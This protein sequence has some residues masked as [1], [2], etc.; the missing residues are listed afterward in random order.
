MR[1]MFAPRDSRTAWRERRRLGVAPGMELDR[2]I[3]EA[4]TLV[5]HVEVLLEGVV[6]RR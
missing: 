2:W 6:G 3:A 5:D 4:E 1:C